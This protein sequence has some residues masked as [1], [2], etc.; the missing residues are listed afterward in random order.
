MLPALDGPLVHT[1]DKPDAMLPAYALSNRI[2]LSASD[3]ALA[4]AEKIVKRITEQYFAP[5]PLPGR[6]ARACRGRK[7]R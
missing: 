2:R 7:R 3:A 1:L 5:Q 6:S 4:E